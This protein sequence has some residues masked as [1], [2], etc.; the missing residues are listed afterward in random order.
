MTGKFTRSPPFSVQLVCILFG[1]IGYVASAISIFIVERWIF[2]IIAAALLGFII[3]LVILVRQQK[4]RG[5][6]AGIIITSVLA[7]LLDSY[8]ALLF[9]VYALQDTIA[10]KPGTFFQ[11]GS[12]SLQPTHSSS[13]TDIEVIEL[14]TP[15]GVHLQ[16][17]LLHGSEHPA[18]LII[19]FG[20]SGSEVSTMIPYFQEIK[21]WSVALVNYRGFGLSEGT[22][23]Q[24]SA[25]ADAVFLYDTFSTRSDVD[26]ARIVSMGYSLGTGIAVFLSEQRPTTA[27]I[28]TAPYD[29]LIF[30]GVKRPGSMNHYQASWSITLIRSRAHRPSPPH[31]FV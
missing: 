25:F 17:W 5:S 18:P 12:A 2:V 31:C 22:P 24:T 1:T 20:G 16:G 26:Q 30:F 3:A 19:Y 10:N 21:S 28:L 23:D 7:V 6:K 8:I 13:S 14:L 15:D 29:S 11:P 9:V 27:T 4:T